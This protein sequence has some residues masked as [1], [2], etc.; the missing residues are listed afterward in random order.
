MKRFVLLLFATILLL[1]MTACSGYNGIMRE[2]LGNEDNYY[3]VDAIFAHTKKLMIA[4]IC[5]S[6]LKT[7]RLLILPNRIAKNLDWN[8]WGIIAIFSM[9]VLPTTK[10]VRAIKLL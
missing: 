10:Y 2:H 1:S 7:N 4:F 3:D 5:M 9:N 8:W 6:P